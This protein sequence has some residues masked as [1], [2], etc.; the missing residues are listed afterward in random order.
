V[1]VLLLQF[2][3]KVQPED[4]MELDEER[5]PELTLDCRSRLG[6]LTTHAPHCP[7]SSPRLRSVLFERILA[8]KVAHLEQRTIQM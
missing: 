8:R 7:A 1:G 4:E 2:W 5:S 6:S 3:G